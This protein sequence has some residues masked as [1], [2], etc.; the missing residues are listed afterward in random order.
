MTA[1]WL[2]RRLS[3]GL[4][5]RLF[6]SGVAM[7]AAAVGPLGAR[8]AQA[9]PVPEAGIGLPRDVSLDGHRIDWLIQITMGFVVILFVIMCIWMFLAVTRH[10][11]DHKAE[12]DHGDAKHQIRFAA[13][14]SALIF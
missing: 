4:S 9:A 5:R 1:S 14:L 7:A 3:R 12:Y 8:L 2:S 10:N 13:G 11:R 6:R